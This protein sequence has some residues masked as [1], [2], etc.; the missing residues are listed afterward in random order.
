[1]A[2]RDDEFRAAVADA[3]PLKAAKRVAPKAPP[4][5][6]VAA[7]RRRDEAAALQESLALSPEDI[8]DADDEASFAR[9]GVARHTLRRLRRGHWTIQAALDLHGLDREQAIAEAAGFLQ[10]SLAR[11]LRCVRIVHGKG[12][13]VLRA[14]LRS[15]LSRRQAVLAWCQAPASQGGGGALLVLLRGKQG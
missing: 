11:G 15:W 9:D 8:L 1:M 5:P 13:G 12:T 4:A 7:Q 3:K 10:K 6:P 2:S 14:T